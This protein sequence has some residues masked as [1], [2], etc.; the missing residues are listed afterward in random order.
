MECYLWTTTGAGTAT[1]T[2]D[3]CASPTSG[4]A[5]PTTPTTTTPTAAASTS[6]APFS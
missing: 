5:P 6:S 2:D 1:G 4:P 3:P